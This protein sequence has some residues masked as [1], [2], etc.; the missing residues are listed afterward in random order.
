MFRTKATTYLQTLDSV[1]A[2]L[3]QRSN[4][5]KPV[6][7]NAA[8]IQESPG[9]NEYFAGKDVEELMQHVIMNVTTSWMI[10]TLKTVPER[11]HFPEPE[12]NESEKAN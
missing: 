10:D 8:L 12:A 11:V 6:I 4:E 2:A 1:I 3:E 5:L 9:H 7:A